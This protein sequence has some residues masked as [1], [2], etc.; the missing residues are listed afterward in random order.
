MIVTI[1]QP[2]HLPWLGFLDKVAK[3]D[4]FVVLDTVQY[5][6]DYFQNRNKIRT[7]KDFVWI[8]IPVNKFSFQT[9]ICDITIFQSKKMLTKYLRQIENNYQHAKYYYKYFDNLQDIITTGYKNL[10]DLNYTLITFLLNCYHIKTKVV[11]ASEINVLSGIGKKTQLNLDICKLTGAKS[12][13]SGISGKDYL[14][15][16]EFLDSGIDVVY[17]KFYHPVY[18][19]LHEPFLPCMS[20]IDLLFNYGE[21]ASEILLG[22]NVKRLDYLI[23]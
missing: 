10:A 5:R 6:K 13:L 1:H 7:A 11:K 2:E 23:E 19:Q 17:Q 16:Q 8:T 20:S 21:N 12:Y 15:V 22:K 14:N 9:K 18:N 3:A 4:L